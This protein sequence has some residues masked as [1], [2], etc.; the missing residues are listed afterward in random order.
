MAITLASL[1]KGLEVKPPL[2]LLYG[3]H[4]VGKSTWASEAPNAV[5]IQTEEGINNLDV[6]KFPKCN[7]VADVMDQLAALYNEEHNF[8]T[9]VLDSIDWFEKIVHR[10]VREIHGE[11][12]FADYGKGYKFSIPF[13]QQ[14]LAGLTALRDKKN[15]QII[16]LGHAKAFQFNAPDTPNYDR[17]APDLHE[18]VCSEVEECCDNVLFAN[19]RVFVVKE[20]VGFGKS[21]GKASGKGDRVVYTQE[22]PP[23]R[24]KNRFWLPQELPM[25]YAAFLKGMRDGLASRKAPVSAPAVV[26]AKDHAPAPTQ[27]D[28]PAAA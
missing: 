28:A 21:E 22:R 6:T 24:A 8:E 10:K 12:I 13:F 16:L 3:V 19:Y 25:S 5:F 27:P 17:Y 4:G 15:M 11:T 9:L 18:S 1:K 7:T 20:D 2:T 26:V 14:L 23:F